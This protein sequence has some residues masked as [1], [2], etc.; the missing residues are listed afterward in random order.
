[1][2]VAVISHIP[3]DQIESRSKKT[4][5]STGG[6]PSYCGLT[7]KE[8]GF[9][10]RLA[11]K[12]GLDFPDEFKRLLAERGV[13]IP[14]RCVSTSS[15]STRFKLVLKDDGRDL[16]LLARCDDITLEDIELDA[17]ACVVSPI[18][19]EVQKDVL[20]EIPKHA[21]FV[22][23]DPQGFLRRVGEDQRIYIART[24]MNLR[25]A[26]ISAIKVDDEEAT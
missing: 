15:P 19:N 3:I 11:T 21:D 23:L 12:I 7:A 8:L 4:A 2:S 1:M 22:F 9:D 20:A 14:R 10:V 25:K 17:D 24:E 18:I 13:R 16:F 5:I 6:P 26:G